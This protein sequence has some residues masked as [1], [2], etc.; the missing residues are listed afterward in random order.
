VKPALSVATLGVKNFARSLHFYK[1]GL[2]WPTTATKKDPIAFFQLTS[3]VLALYPRKLLAED[4]QVSAKGS[5][6]PGI[7]FAH[8]TGS[9]KEVKQVLKQAQKAGA[10]IV[11]KAQKVFWGGY[12][13]YFTDPDGYLWEVVHNPKWKLDRRGRVVSFHGAG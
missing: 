1:K 8:N 10:K 13:G 2:G 5:G 9:E 6:F 11:K 12:S 4:A 7:T 3:L